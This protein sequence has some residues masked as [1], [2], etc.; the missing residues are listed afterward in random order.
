MRNGQITVLVLLLALMGLTVGL[1]QAS[2]SLSDLKQISYVDVGTKVYAGA[3]TGLQYA[4]NQFNS[5]TDY[6]TCASGVG[7]TLPNG[8]ITTSY[9][10]CGQASDS[11][12]TTL[13]K[14]S[15]VAVDLTS[16][17][18][19][20][21]TDWRFF[22][23]Y[24]ASLVVTVVKDNGTLLRYAY[25]GIN[26]SQNNGFVPSK[27]GNDPACEDTGSVYNYCALIPSSPSPKDVLIR[28][29]AIGGNTGLKFWAKKTGSTTPILISQTYNF[30]ATATSPNGTKKRLQVVKTPP[31]LPSIFDYTIFSKGSVIK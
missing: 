13:L 29:K 31:T 1:S 26:N 18:Y 14:D 27:A 9:Q 8:G 25:N 2:R 17:N 6:S 24:P 3:E 11:F 4:L 16:K 7:P 22:W 12:T 5:A 28:I 21:N 15:V 10:I 20:P 19:P 23:N 30:I